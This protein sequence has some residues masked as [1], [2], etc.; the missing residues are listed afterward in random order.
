MRCDVFD[1]ARA[2]ALPLPR[3]GAKW[4]PSRPYL[5]GRCAG[6]HPRLVASKLLAPPSS[7]RPVQGVA[8]E[9]GHVTSELRTRMRKV[10]RTTEAP[11][12]RRRR[13]TRPPPMNRRRAVFPPGPGQGLHPLVL[14]STASVSSTVTMCSRRRR[15]ETPSG[16][17]PRVPAPDQGT[18]KE[19][20]YVQTYFRY[21]GRCVCVG[22]GGTH[23]GG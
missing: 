1:G 22:K 23:T 17:G 3:P 14:L 9:R 11:R 4:L 18:D 7:R 6:S 8:S 12:R 19:P 21:Y 15:A 5:A 2:R 20:G 10:P 13:G 16:L